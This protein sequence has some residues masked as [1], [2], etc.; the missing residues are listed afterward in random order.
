MS[1]INIEFVH[2]QFDG[3]LFVKWAK[4]D[5]KRLPLNLNEKLLFHFFSQQIQ[6]ATVNYW[7][8]NWK[9]SLSS[10]LSLSLSLSLFICDEQKS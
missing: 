5:G 3:N 9:A 2:L 8:P 10:S 1:R 7:Q 4:S 6:P